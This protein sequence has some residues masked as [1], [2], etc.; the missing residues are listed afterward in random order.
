[1]STVYEIQED[2]DELSKE[3]KSHVS[4]QHGQHFEMMIE[5]LYMK[6]RTRLQVIQEKNFK[7]IR[8][9]VIVGEYFGPP[10][11][12]KREIESSVARRELSG[13]ASSAD[14]EAMELLS[15]YQTDV[16]QV[17]NV[18]RNLDE[19]S[20]V[21]SV[22]SSRA[23][24]QGELATSVL[25]TAA[26]SIMYIDNAENQLKRAIDNNSSFRLYIVLWFI[27]LSM[28]L[29]ILDLISK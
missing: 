17:V 6:L 5:I 12:L 23:I 9:E 1:M 10:S 7:R 16:D 19:L 22:L 28:I 11:V 2:I 27:C 25:E 21:L 26:D 13:S 4:E 20:S 8:H 15:M 14:M 24:E 29:I 3:T 18:R